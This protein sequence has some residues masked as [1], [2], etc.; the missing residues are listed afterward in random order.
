[1][2]ARP[3][4]RGHDVFG[5][6][7]AFRQSRATEPRLGENVRLDAATGI[8]TAA[9]DGS[10]QFEPSSI[11]VSNLLHVK[12][13][14]DFATGNI[15]F[16][17]DVLVA[18]G[19]A[20]LFEVSA[21][22]V[23][24]RGAVEAATVR[25]SRNLFVAGGIIAKEKGICHAGT[26]LSA[27]FISN[28]HVTC[29]G[30]VTVL[31]E[32]NN[33]QVTCTGRLEVR[34]GAVLSGHVIANG[35]VCAKSLG[36][37]SEARTIVEVGLEPA[38]LHEAEPRLH[39]LETRKQNIE[40]ARMLVAPLMGHPRDL[41]RAQREKATELLYLA[42]QHEAKLKHALGD[43][44][45]RWQRVQEMRRLEIEVLDR[46]YPGVVLRFPGLQATVQTLIHG[47]AKIVLRQV[48][49]DWRIFVV[50]TYRHSQYALE[51]TPT[52]VNHVER[53]LVA[54]AA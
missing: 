46:V 20:D 17:G 16:S 30:N 40:H 7:I 24:I 13:N 15:E 53:R 8:I 43:L 28:A 47:P 39:E 6:E 34:E 32:V 27:R 35:G 14:V 42:N 49:G 26:A 41:T 18:G 9:C 5:K 38:I 50:N 11:D 1:L 21:K 29:G 52:E 4:T 44:L 10:L 25:A 54:L 23:T 51:A 3:G 19:V 33:S 48:K 45:V 22:N 37:S 31:S 2:P 12:R 36:S